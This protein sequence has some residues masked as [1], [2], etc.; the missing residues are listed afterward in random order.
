M[1]AKQ[2]PNLT[3]EMQMFDYW[4][5]VYSP[6]DRHID[7]L[8]AAYDAFLQHYTLPR[9]D[10]VI[11]EDFS[12]Q[13]SSHTANL[14]VFSPSE[15]AEATQ[16]S[17]V[18]YVHGGGSVVGSVD[19]HEFIARQ[20]ARDVK[21]KVFLLEYGL[22]PEFCWDQGVEDCVDAFVKIV[23]NAT[24]WQIYAQQNAIVADGSGCEIALKMLQNLQQKQ[25][26]V[27]QIALLFPSF[28]S[29]ASASATS[30][31]SLV[32][33]I[34]N[35]HQVNTWFKQDLDPSK[36]RKVPDLTS[37]QGSKTFV[38]L[39]E[40]DDSEQANQALLQKLELNHTDLQIEHGKGLRNSCLPLLRDCPETASIYNALTQF[41]SQKFKK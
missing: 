13:L 11:V 25:H 26:P 3:E 33:Q 6:A 23:E 16:G 36:L 28:A 24:K 41:L 29:D 12:F 34:E 1:N 18:F 17:W 2:E 21:T 27:D 9:T 30:V 15:A 39:A 8:R 32:Y 5:K 35:Q 31:S 14:R 40:Y 4:S 19:S 22:V 20:I 7:S 38:A 37:M 10:Q